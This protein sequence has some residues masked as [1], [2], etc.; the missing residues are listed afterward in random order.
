M[1]LV[2]ETAGNNN[3]SFNFLSLRPALNIFLL[4]YFCFFWKTNSSPITRFGWAQIKQNQG[5]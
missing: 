2:I 5:A 3:G 1:S 4:T